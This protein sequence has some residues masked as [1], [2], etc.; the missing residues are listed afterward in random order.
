MAEGSPASTS[1]TPTTIAD[2]L[3]A[4]RAAERRLSAG[5]G[6]PVHLLQDVARWR[7]EY[8]RRMELLAAAPPDGALILES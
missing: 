1:D 7:E 8:Q 4:W 3:R 2:V 5:E 6:N